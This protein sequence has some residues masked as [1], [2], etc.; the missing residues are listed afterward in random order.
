[1]AMSI[2][3]EVP[4]TLSAFVSWLAKNP[5]DGDRPYSGAGVRY[6]VA[7]YCDYLGGNPWP[8]GDPLREHAARDGAVLAYSIYLDTFNT[9]SAT[10]GMILESLDRFYVFL[11]LGAVA[12]S[13]PM[14]APSAVAVRRDA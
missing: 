5:V 8:G 7:R 13:A 11:G 14:P 10:I 1:M 3:A 6:H 9:P 12:S 4:A 2:R